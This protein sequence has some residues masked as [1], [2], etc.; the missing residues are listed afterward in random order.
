MFDETPGM[1][2]A[3]AAMPVRRRLPIYGE[4]PADMAIRVALDDWAYGAW[5]ERYAD[6]EVATE[7]DGD[8]AMCD[9]SAWDFDVYVRKLIEIEDKAGDDAD[10]RSILDDII[11]EHDSMRE[12][13]LL[14]QA[15]LVVEV[16]VSHRCH[17]V[18]P[19]APPESG[20]VY[21]VAGVVCYRCR[22][23]FDFESPLEP[24][25]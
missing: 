19:I 1:R 14:W 25:P 21:A 6:D 17:M 2:A 9:L 12:T 20:G 10:P 3:R 24:K 23:S 8:I 18:E 15:P 4:R 13:W 7:I 11:C 16:G 22:F 5:F